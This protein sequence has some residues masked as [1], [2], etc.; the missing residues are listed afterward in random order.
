MILII[1][2]EADHST[3][4]VL[5]WLHFFKIDHL[6]VNQEDNLTISVK[7]NDI[8]IGN[9]E[10]SFCLSEIKCVWY[11]RGYLNIKIH[12]TD[13]NN[14]NFFL[15]EEVSKIK[16]YIYY[17]LSNL[18]NIN[19]FKNADVNKLIVNEIASKV[20]LNVP[21]EYLVTSEHDLIKLR[22]QQTLATKSI[23]G[24]TMFFF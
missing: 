6:R 16:E 9:E 12:Y 19:D 18:P 10:F 5:D 1:T 7:N 23:T 8:I 21:L 13:N 2:N 4:L 11:R 15:K 3:N 14:L 24:S 20:G 17:K 22:K